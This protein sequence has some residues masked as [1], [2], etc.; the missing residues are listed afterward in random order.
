MTVDLADQITEL[1]QVH[2]G[3]IEIEQTE[4][5]TILAGSL[6]FEASVD[7]HSPITATFDIELIVPDDYPQRLPR[8]RE[9]GG[10]IDSDYEH[11]YDDETLCLAVPIEER[12]LFWEQ[13]TL[14][15]FV[16]KLVI[17]YFFGYC[18]WKTHG[19]HPFEEQVHGVEGIMKHYVDKLHD[20]IRSLG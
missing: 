17:P 13:P 3:L 11:V 6:P 7:G 15:G 2:N 18:H 19:E 8:V 20:A 5:E 4:N 1:Q 9:K 12:R 10:R 14:L 16:N